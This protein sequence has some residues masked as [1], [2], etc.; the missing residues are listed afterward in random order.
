MQTL[1]LTVTGMSCGGCV[2]SVTNILSA[3]PGI[4][5]VEVTLD[6]GQA[7]VTY[8]PVRIDRDAM[9]RAIAAAGFGAS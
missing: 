9:I 2:A 7:R 3:L 4:E 6:P 5:S 1:V 8:D